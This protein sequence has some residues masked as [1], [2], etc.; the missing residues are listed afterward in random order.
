MISNRSILKHILTICSH[1]LFWIVIYYFYA[2]F[3]GYGSSNTKYVNKF[4]GF[5]MPVTILVS[6][7]FVYY[8][9]PNYL[10]TK[11]YVYFILYSI[12]TF[13][14]S[15]FIIL[16]SILYGLV[17][18][19]GFKEMGTVP[20]TK[21]LPFIILGVYFVVL[22]FVSFSLIM[23][24]YK[25]IVSNE[26]LKNK[27]LE[28]QL[29]IKDQELRFLKMQIHPHFLFNSL[30][31]IYGFALNKKDEAPEMILKLSNLLDYIL[32]QIEKPQVFLMD[33]INHL[34]DY[35]SLEK[36]RFHDTLEVETTVNI[37]SKNIQIAPM[38]L[39]PFV[40]NAFK[41]GDIINGSLYVSI[42][43]KTDNNKLF[44]EIENTSIKENK[45]NNGIGLENIAK[46]L[47]MLYPN[48]HTL[49]T[50]QT[51]SFFKVKL[52]IDNLKQFKNE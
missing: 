11:K 8:L 36:M 43:I 2:Y 39:I 19:E 49:E 1:I 35:V 25:S 52:T 20:L 45:T 33:E 24:N 40:E 51:D 44:F 9:I 7:F 23:Y 22:I 26:N 48:S 37:S 14:L 29:Q 30:N 13:I 21:T 38:L 5:L 50:F 4:S 10:L 17:Y 16:V 32:Y 6:Y 27:I 46:R 47:K 3:L 15:V 31:T 42:Q 12:Y 28:T 34:Q 18:S 41:H